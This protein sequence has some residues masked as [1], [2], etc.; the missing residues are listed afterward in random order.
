M[1]DQTPQKRSRGRPRSI[2]NDKPVATVQAL[3][4]AMTLLTALAAEDK[5]TLTELSLRVGMSPSTAHRLLT[6]LQQ[7]GVTDFDETTQNWMVGVEAFRIGASFARRTQVA[8]AGREVM[9]A[10]M[11]DTGETAN[12]GIADQGDVVF[13]SQVETSNPI[14]A[15]FRPGTRA[16]MH[17]SGIGKALMAEFSRADVEKIMQRKG[18]P[19]FTPKT[20]V[21]SERLLADLATIRERRWSLDDE[22]NNLGMRCLAAAIFNEFGEPVAGV[23]ISGPT[24]RLEDERLAEL[25]PRVRRAA[26]EITALIGGTVPGRHEPSATD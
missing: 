17:A 23:S 26:E 10:L 19:A 1:A 24:V 15:F 20:L 18:L 4:R 5:I 14:R 3:D 11:T 12:M 22:E 2:W 21:A 7:H 9:R 13:I 16:H 25:G 8:E 6:T